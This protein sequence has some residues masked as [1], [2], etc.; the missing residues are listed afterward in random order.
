MLGWEQ[1]TIDD[2]NGNIYLEFM[3]RTNYKVS[4]NLS[5]ISTFPFRPGKT[6]SS[7]PRPLLNQ[8]TLDNAHEYQWE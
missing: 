8:G 5:S 4:V 1:P 2:S 7:L 3:R 6:T